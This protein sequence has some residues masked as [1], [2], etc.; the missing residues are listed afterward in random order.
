MERTKQGIGLRQFWG[1]LLLVLMPG[2]AWGAEFSALMM[3]KDGPKIF[4]GKVYVQNGKMR[5]EFV[6]E[7]GQT[8]TIV[9]PDK[10]VVWVVVPAR[11][12]YLEMPLKTKLPGQFIQIPPQALQKRLV[13]KDW[14]NGYETDKYEVTV[15]GRRGNEQQTFWMAQKL[16]QPIKMESRQRQFSLEYKSIKEEKVPDHLFDL[17]VG[18]RKATTPQGFY[19]DLED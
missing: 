2:I 6:D 17:P 1:L 14:V 3:L 15:P 19:R 7:Q 11:R 16:G 9:R 18:Y 5:Q 4:P 10:K 13:G 8:V 12:S